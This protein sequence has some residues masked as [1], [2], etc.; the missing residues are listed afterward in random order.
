M[1]PDYKIIADSNDITAVIRSRFLELRVT[2]ESGITSDTVEIDL[3]DREPHIELPRKG[4]ALEVSIGYK[5]TGIA[6][7]GRY[8]VDEAELSGPPDT[9]TI[10]AK[11]ADMRE[12]L[13][14]PV[15]KSFDNISLGNLV[16]TIAAK[17][18]LTPFVAKS[19]SAITLTHLDQTNESDLHLLTRLA[20]DHGAVAKP[21]GGKLLFVL[22]G[23]A[24]TATGK[25]LPALNLDR[26]D[27]DTWR[28][29]I[30]DRGKYM[31]VIAYWRDK[32]AGDDVQVTAGTGDPVYTIRR[33]YPDA[34]SALSAAK[35]KLASFESGAATLRFTKAGDNR[36]AA[37]GS[38][39][40]SGVRSGV[41]GAW[42][43]TRVTHTINDSGYR[44]DGEA[45]TKG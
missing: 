11:S 45:E 42:K 35:S 12:S 4:A 17:H 44:C 20:K 36:L 22:A 43:T 26:S 8:V 2:D 29:T 7:M 30:A 28:V 6:L 1:T 18:G 19:L 14:S 23:E 27:L 10:R 3:D 34:G 37:E 9:V 15:S 32:S 31:S 24:K 13:K 5:E 39:N 40:I 41:N 25:T 21:A 33:H 38:L 16:A